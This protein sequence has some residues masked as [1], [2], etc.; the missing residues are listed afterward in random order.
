MTNTDFT[1]KPVPKPSA[2]SKLA[3]IWAV[4]DKHGIKSF[5]NYA[6]IRSVAETIKDTFCKWLDNSE[7]PCVFLVPP[8]GPFRAENYQSGAYSVSGTGYLPLKPMTFGLAVRISQDKDYMRLVLHCRKE[9]EIMKISIGE[10]SPISLELPI[11]ETRLEPVFEQLH[12]HILHFFQDAIDRY[13]EGDYGT[14]AIGFDI[15]RVEE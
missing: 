3:E 8:E 4:A 5:D 13:D 1:P 11:D 14:S 7:G 9:G 15:L 2:N 12:S 6:Q 10:E